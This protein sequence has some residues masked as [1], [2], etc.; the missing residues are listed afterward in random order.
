M[1]PISNANNPATHTESSAVHLPQCVGHASLVAQEGSKVD[2]M[3]GIIFGPR[4]HPAPV[5][6]ASLVGQKAYVSMSGRVELS[7]RLEMESRKTGMRLL[8]TQAQ[9]YK[10]A[11][12]DVKEFATNNTEVFRILRGVENQNDLIFSTEKT[13]KCSKHLQVRPMVIQNSK[14]LYSK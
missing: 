4:A 7:M 14:K 6:L 12:S 2:W 13:K 1:H 9:G 8:E 10:D 5:P 3:A 11:V